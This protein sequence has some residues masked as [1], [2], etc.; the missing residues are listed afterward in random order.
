MKG[1]NNYRKDKQKYCSISEKSVPRIHKHN[2]SGLRYSPRKL[3]NKCML[4]DKTTKIHSHNCHHTCILCYARL[5]KFTSID[6][7]EIKTSFPLYTSFME[8]EII[9]SF[10]SIILWNFTIPHA[11]KMNE[12]RGRCT[13]TLANHMWWIYMC[14]YVYNYGPKWTNNQT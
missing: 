1:W 14:V 3:S 8:Q 13:L 6:P 12:S 4:T 9:L 5:Y 11:E 10:K 7:Q 2:A